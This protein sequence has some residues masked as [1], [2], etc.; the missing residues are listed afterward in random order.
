M[1]GS[2]AWWYRAC[3]SLAAAAAAATTGIRASVQLNDGSWCMH[4]CLNTG[5][6]CASLSGTCQ[7]PP[8]GGALHG[9]GA[10][11]VA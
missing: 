3:G 9:P 10:Q 5:P 8:V 1:A 6:L 4:S 2:V 7:V 11:N